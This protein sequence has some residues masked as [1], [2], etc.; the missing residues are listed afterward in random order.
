MNGQARLLQYKQDSEWSA[1][2]ERPLLN[3]FA[4]NTGQRE[5]GRLRAR[6][7]GRSQVVRRLG[8]AEEQLSLVDFLNA[9]LAQPKSNG[10][11]KQLQLKWLK[12]TFDDLPNQP[13]LPGIDRS[14]NVAAVPGPVPTSPSRPARRWREL[15]TTAAGPESADRD[16]DERLPC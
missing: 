8:R 4:F 10:T 9:F 15:I 7:A 12:I 13:L 11:Y 14:N 3:P 1:T 5:A 16:V 6:P 2:P